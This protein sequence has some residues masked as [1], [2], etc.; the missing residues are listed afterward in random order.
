MRFFNGIHSEDLR[1]VRQY[2]VGNFISYARTGF[3]IFGMR[4]LLHLNKIKIPTKLQRI[5]VKRKQRTSLLKQ[6][7]TSVK[8]YSIMEK[9]NIKEQNV[10]TIN[11]KK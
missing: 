8:F 7:P 5:L 9:I 2:T 10:K 3:C 1:S 6:K 11:P 4:H